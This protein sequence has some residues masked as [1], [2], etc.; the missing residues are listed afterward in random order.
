LK[1]GRYDLVLREKARRLDAL[2][3]ESPGVLPRAED[4]E[5]LKMKYMVSEVLDYFGCFEEA[6]KVLTAKD[7]H[8]AVQQQLDRRKKTKLGVTN[9]KTQK[10]AREQVRFRLEY[11]QSFYRKHWHDEAGKIIEECRDLMEK[12]IA[13]GDTF[14]C[15]GTRARIAFYLA[16]VD[17][18]L[19]RYSDAELHF[20]EAIRYHEQRAQQTLDENRGD[21]NAKNVRE[22]MEFARH[23]SAIAMALGIGWLCYTTGALWRAKSYIEPAQVASLEIVDDGTSGDFVVGSRWDVT[24]PQGFAHTGSVHYKAADTALRELVADEAVEHL[25]HDIEPGIKDDDRCGIVG[26]GLNE[27]ARQNTVR[28][29]YFDAFQGQR[30]Q[31]NGV[32]EGI[33]RG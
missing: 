26:G 18:Q 21:R 28:R 8:K 6:E 15:L 9:A 27:V 23:K 24:Q 7:T 11:A 30:H 29:F 1:G 14:R 20:L 31:G 3:E 33:H 5:F 19:N 10:L 32:C 4:R 22:E 25:L 12:H 16:R 13:N 17:R 2:L